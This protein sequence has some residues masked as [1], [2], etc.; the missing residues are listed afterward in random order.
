[1]NQYCPNDACRFVG[2]GYT[3]NVHVS[4]TDQS[5]QPAIRGPCLT[6]GVMQYR[7][8]TEDQQPAQI[9]IPSFADSLQSLLPATGMLPA[10]QTE[11]SGQLPS[12]LEGGNVVTDRRFQSAG[13]QGT[14]SWYLF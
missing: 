9:A 2:L 6:H 7:T 14:D 12:I 5:L 3:G 1:M 11:E 13:S 10:D 4:S 8:S